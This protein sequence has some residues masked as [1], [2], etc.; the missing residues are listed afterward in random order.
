E[1]ETIFDSPVQCWKAEVES[2]S[3]DIQLQVDSLDEDEDQFW[4]ELIEKY[5][6]PLQNDKENQEKTKNELQ[7]LRNKAS[8]EDWNA[9]CLRSA[10]IYIYIFMLTFINFSFFFVNALWLVAAFVF[11]VFKIFQIQINIVDLNLNETGGKFQVEPMSLMFILG[12]AISVLLQFIGMLCHRVFTIIHFVA[13]LETE[14]KQ[15]KSAAIKQNDSMSNADSNSGFSSITDQNNIRKDETD[16]E[17]SDGWDSGND[18]PE[19]DFED[20]TE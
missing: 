15:Q 2:L 8:M 16:H 18:S 4:K 6:E 7:E 20:G 12:F 13:F 10:R 3:S 5:L 14:P 1:E 11:Q 19:L 17:L 9:M